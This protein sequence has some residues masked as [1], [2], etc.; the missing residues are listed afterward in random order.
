MLMKP[1]VR[2]YF[3]I[4]IKDLSIVLI[5]GTSVSSVRR[6]YSGIVDDMP[7]DT[8]P[9]IEIRG[10]KKRLYD[11]QS[12]KT[13]A[14]VHSMLKYII[15]PWN[16]WAFAVYQ[17]LWVHLKVDSP[18]EKEEELV[19]INH[20][21]YAMHPLLSLLYPS[22]W[23]SCNSTFSLTSVLNVSAKII[24]LSS[25]MSTLYWFPASYHVQIKL[26]IFT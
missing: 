4:G 19:E 8:M 14:K 16:Y 18:V 7:V 15:Y 9:R 22:L 17:H 13:I 20:C 24:F 1:I 3:P 11:V 12:L 2:K 23:P 5:L 26:F 6:M 10:L 21:Q 25:H